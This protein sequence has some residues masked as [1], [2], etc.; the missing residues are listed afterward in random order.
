MLKWT[1]NVTFNIGFVNRILRSTN[2]NNKERHM[3]KW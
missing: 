2:D 3:K 1:R